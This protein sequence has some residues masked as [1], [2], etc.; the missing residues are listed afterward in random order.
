M[1][2]IHIAAGEN[3]GLKKKTKEPICNEAKK[4]IEL[5][6]TK[7]RQPKQRKHSAT[8]SNSQDSLLCI[9]IQPHDCR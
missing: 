8:S 9:K 1:G 5:E 6:I 2:N 4:N 3:E 7:R